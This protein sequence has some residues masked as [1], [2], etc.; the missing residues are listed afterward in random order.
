MLKSV[1]DS[2]TK[3]FSNLYLV[4]AVVILGGIIYAYIA[5]QGVAKDWEKPSAVRVDMSQFE[6]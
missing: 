1:I 6:E 2:I 4:G 3:F 5:A